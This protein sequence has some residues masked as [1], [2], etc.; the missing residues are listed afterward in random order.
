MSDNPKSPAPVSVGNSRLQQ[1]EPPASEPSE[2]EPSSDRYR[3]E[4]W[5]DSDPP[6]KY[7]LG[8]FT[9]YPIRFNLESILFQPGVQF[10][11]KAVPV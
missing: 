6:V 7:I 8:T 2:R 9:G 5:V 10:T 1:T 3:W 11:I 4:L